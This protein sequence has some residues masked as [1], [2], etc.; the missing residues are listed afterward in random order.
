VLLGRLMRSCGLSWV[1][2]LSAQAVFGL[3]AAN[4]ETLAWSVQW[5]AVLST[6]FMLLALD[7]FFR[8]PSGAAPIAWAAASAL[9]FSRGILTGPMLACA[10]LW[11][12]VSG[13]VDSFRR[14][15]AIAAAC[16]APAV[17]VS[18]VIFIF[19]DTGNEHHMSGHWG[20]AAIFGAWYYCLNPA[21]RVLGTGPSGYGA[22]FLLGF[23]KLALVGWAL[24]RSHGRQRLLFV[25]LVAFDIGNAVLLGVGRFHTGAALAASSRYQYASLIGFLP[26]AGYCLSSLGDRLPGPVAI[27]R[28]VFS[29]LLAVAAVGM[30]LQWRSVLGPFSEWR[31]TNS[32]R[33]FLNETG[34]GL[35]EVPGFAAFPM[36]RAKA[37]IQR[38]TLH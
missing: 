2:V 32:R 38:Y 9:S 17:A 15:A 28:V 20:E 33:I 13:P 7:S 35:Q 10:C 31:G 16:L 23:L 36:E 1:A 14:R 22:V 12:I 25:L 6:T 18:L 27:R 8:R 30:G 26:L 29:A 3:T 11:P 4:L 21:V 19:A 5:S 37:L 24:T 34:P